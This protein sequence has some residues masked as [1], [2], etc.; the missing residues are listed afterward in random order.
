MQILSKIL[1][2]TVTALHNSD[3]ARVAEQAHG[4]LA[5]DLVSIVKEG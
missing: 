3:I 1:G 2:T 5:A 4:F